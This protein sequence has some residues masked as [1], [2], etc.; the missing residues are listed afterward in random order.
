[1]P[2]PSRALWPLALVAFATSAAAQIDSERALEPVVIVGEDAAP[3][4]GA[5]P[6]TVLA[7]RWGG[8]GWEPVP[9]QVDERALVDVA[10]AYGPLDPFDCDPFLFCVGLR[11]AVETL[12]WTDTGTFLGPDPDATLD[13]DDEIAL[14]AGDGGP[15]APEATPPP[16]GTAPGTLTEVQLADEASGATAY[17]YL[18]VGDGTGDPA[19]GADRVRYAFDLLSGDY[20]ETYDLAGTNAN[21]GEP[22]GDALGS[23]PESTTVETDRYRLHYSDRWILDGLA[24]GDG[25]DLLDRRKVLFNPGDC[26]RHETTGSRGEGA[27]V[28]NR[29]GPVRAIRSVIGFNSG[30]LTQ[31]T[32]VFWP[33]RVVSTTDL[34]VHAIPGVL[35]AMDYAPEATGMLYRASTMGA[36]VTVDGEPD[37]ASDSDE[38]LAWETLRGSAGAIVTRHDAEGAAPGLFFEDDAEGPTTQCTGDGAALATSGPWVSDGVPNSDPRL[39]AAQSFRAT[40]TAVLTPEPL[41]APEAQAVLDR[42][43]SPLAVT[44]TSRAVASGE[45]P[46]AAGLAVTVWPNPSRGRVAV[47]FT[48]AAP[49]P[50]RLSVLDAL[51]REV[52]SGARTPRAAGAHRLEV[53]LG[54]LAPG[55]YL[56]R[57]ETGAGVV[58]RPVTRL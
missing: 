41:T 39:G 28:V 37:G 21:G 27:F 54:G 2:R 8:A 40:R 43:A 12:F 42:L 30:P 18:A 16:A 17:V 45:G 52:T 51:G 53:D 15:R 55:A 1:M 56:V 35:D 29:D 38:P 9:V 19:A 31:R 44:V 6:Q 57:L 33:G 50:V 32:D 20:R 5:A 7:F 25:P 22:V 47:R 11:G 4:L 48:L 24:L 13:A 34:R 49:G 3:L 36:E 23:N 26:D 58:A 46:A 14:V 10:D